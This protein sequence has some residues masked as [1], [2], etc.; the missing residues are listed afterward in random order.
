MSTSDTMLMRPKRFHHVLPPLL[1][2]LAWLVVH[3][4]NFAQGVAWDGTRAAQRQVAQRVSRKRE[5][6]RSAQDEA[7]EKAEVKSLTKRMKKA[8][9]A[10]ELIDVLD[11]AM[12]GPVFD[13]IHA[14]AAYTRLVTLKKGVP[15]T[16]GL[17]ESGA[18]QA[19][20]SS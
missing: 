12:G 19:A 6:T 17:G 7:D 4:L 5:P 1:L 14:S 15:A 13:F 8:P 20:R 11:E 10:K 2:C 3:Q 16:R 9:S 18:S